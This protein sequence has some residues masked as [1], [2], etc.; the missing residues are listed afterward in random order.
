MATVATINQQ[1]QLYLSMIIQ[2]TQDHR[3][4]TRMQT[5]SQGIR[6]NVTKEIDVDK[7]VNTKMECKFES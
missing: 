7:F 3:P 2:D 6:K 4:K 1:V 5:A